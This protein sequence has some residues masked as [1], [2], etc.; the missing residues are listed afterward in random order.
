MAKNVL[1]VGAVDSFAQV[2]SF[3]SRGPAYDGRIKPDVMAQGQSTVLSD[4]DGNVV[5]SNGTSFSGPIIAGMT[6]CLWQAFPNK[7]NQQI[8]EMILASSDRYKAPTNQYG[9][10]IPDF[11]KAY[12]LKLQGKLTVLCLLIYIVYSSRI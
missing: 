4:E 6:A 9:Y 2:Q 3:S 5:T 11:K 8:K 7:T 10:G 1:L 12:N